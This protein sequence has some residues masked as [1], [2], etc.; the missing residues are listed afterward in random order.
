MRKIAMSALVAAGVLGLGF[1]VTG[2]AGAY[3]VE[4]TLPAYQVDL[5]HYSPLIEPNPYPPIVY[6]G[7]TYIP[8]TWDN[9]QRLQLAL[10]WQEGEGLSIRQQPNAQAPLVGPESGEK[11]ND[12]N[13]TY[14]AR[15]A[16]YPITVNGKPIDNAR[17]EYPVL[18]FRDIPYFPL[19]WRF[20]REEFQWATAWSPENGYSV[21]SGNHASY[22]I[23]GIVADDKSSLYVS[24]HL[25]GTV[26]LNKSLAGTLSSVPPE[27]NGEL[28]KP[29]PA[30]GLWSMEGHPE[31]LI[32]Q[33]RIEEDAV[34]LEGTQLLSI[35]ELLNEANRNPSGKVYT[36]ED[37]QLE[38]TVIPLGHSRLI[39]V[40]TSL[41]GLSS[42]LLLEH[43]GKVQELDRN[44]QVYR[45]IPAGAGRYW[46]SSAYAQSETH[47]YY[48]RHEQHLW[49]VDE[50]GNAGSMNGTLGG[51]P[52]IRVLTG[53]QDGSVLVLASDN[54]W[55]ETAADIYRIQPNGKAEKLFSALRGPIYADAAGEIY[56][57]SSEN[58]R[59]TK[60]S[61]GDSVVLTDR[62]LFL[63][64]HGEPQQVSPRQS[65][66]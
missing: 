28:V 46:I 21:V 31:A 59:I 23:G 53:L 32:R 48:S 55:A 9:C 26:R 52:M 13:Q 2:H 33:T 7:I 3:Q 24:T 60:L 45:M 14:R 62:M 15:I 38:D 29:D 27:P 4:V 40:E 37:V 6:K 8:M 35:K 58:D 63:T 51:V 57:L 39:Q 36:A 65:G 5:N 50:T 41:P 10:N 34:L 56:Q 11:V 25:Y 43:E 22:D 44:H 54:D 49:L 42:I 18:S 61:N 64:A 47:T 66:S 20:T 1:P 30:K 16:D 19:T 12:L 17:E